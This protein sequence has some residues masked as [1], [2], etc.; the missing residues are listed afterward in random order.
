MLGFETNSYT[1]SEDARMLELNVVLVEGI[2]ERNV[3]TRISITDMEAQLVQDFTI[4]DSIVTF[5]AGMSTGDNQKIV[6]QLVDD[7][8]VEIDESFSIELV[9]DDNAVRLATKSVQITIIDND[10]E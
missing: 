8:L 9:S 5:P 6:V 7:Q 4:V 2:L 10:G 1:I 3:S